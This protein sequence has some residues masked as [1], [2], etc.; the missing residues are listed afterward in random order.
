M[1]REN[2][3]VNMTWVQTIRDFDLT[4]VLSARKK[5]FIQYVRPKHFLLFNRNTVLYLLYNTFQN[6][7]HM[8]NN[9]SERQTSKLTS[10]MGASVSEYKQNFGHPWVT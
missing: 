6:V 2:K 10:L 7:N 9:F 5:T 1:W 8:Y 3:L 4:V